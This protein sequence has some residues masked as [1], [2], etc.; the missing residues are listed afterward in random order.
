MSL[1]VYHY[2]LGCSDMLRL[3][4]VVTHI[5]YLVYT[6]VQVKELVYWADPSREHYMDRYMSVMSDSQWSIYSPLT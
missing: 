2:G 6:W 5:R 3:A 1:V 4:C